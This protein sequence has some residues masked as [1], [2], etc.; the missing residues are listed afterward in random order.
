MRIATLDDDID[1]LQLTRH[2]VEA[3]GHSYHPFQDGEQ[4][5]GELRHEC[6][7]LLILDWQ[8]PGLSGLEVLHRLRNELRSHMPVLMLTARATEADIV[9]GLEA[10][11]DD[12]MVKPFRSGELAARLKALL[13]RAFTQDMRGH[14]QFGDYGFDV[15]AGQASWRGEPITLKPKEFELALYMFNNLGKLLSR[16]HL[17]EAVWG[18]RGEPVS[19]SVDTHLSRI[20]KQLNL[21]PEQG[22]R[23]VSVYSHGYRLEAVGPGQGEAP[24]MTDSP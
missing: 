1:H 3:L 24:E 7:D 19:R 13:R 12:Y 8:L 22:Y 10:G 15:A 23:L 14:Y 17:M 2:A 4:L 5:L 16:A 11:A 20:R 18:Q 6:F 21:R 9:E